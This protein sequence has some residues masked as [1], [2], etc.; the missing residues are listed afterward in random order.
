M[1]SM[2]AHGSIRLLEADPDLGRFLSAEDRGL[3]WNVRVPLVELAPGEVDIKALLRASHAFAALVVDGLLLQSLRLQE[4]AGLRLLGPGS[5]LSLTDSPE[6]MLVLDDHLRATVTCQLALLGRDFLVITRRWPWFAAGLNSRAAEQSEQLLTQLMICQL[7][8][9]DDRL[10]SM[11]WLLAETWGRVTPSGT[12]LPLHLTH[13]ALGGLIGARRP[14]VTLALRGLSESGAILRQTDGWLLLQEPEIRDATGSEDV[15]DLRPLSRVPA[16]WGFKTPPTALD[17]E[18]RLARDAASYAELRRTVV[19]LAT[20][21]RDSARA[22]QERLEA[23][24]SSRKLISDRR[25]RIT[26]RQPRRPAP[27]S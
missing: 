8:R 20:E 3:A 10:L 18:A 9:V 4:Q 5:N 11:M 24:R 1:R 2:A 17:D 6:S 16:Q 26:Q 27:S 13:S 22:V 21:H 15:G 23:V 12:L 14:T 25:A 7:P 19:R